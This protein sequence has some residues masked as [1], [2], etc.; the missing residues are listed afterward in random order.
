MAASISASAGGTIWAPVAARAA[1]AGAQVD[2]VAVVLRRVVA[3]GD[4]HAG[5]RVEGA[6]RVRQHRGGQH[7]RQHQRPAAGAGRDPG[8]LLGEGARAAAGVVADRPA[9]GR[10]LASASQATSPAAACRTTA[11]FMPFGPAR[12]RPA[13]P[14]GAEGQRSGEP[15]GELV[16]GIRQALDDGAQLRLAGRVGVVGQPPLGPVRSASTSMSP[17][18]S[19]DA[20]AEGPAVSRHASHASDRSRLAKPSGQTNWNERTISSKMILLSANRASG[21]V[22]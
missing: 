6:H 19:V 7:P 11:R 17:A 3:R 9:A 13:Q 15:V 18:S 22:R 10:R 20:C 8:G 4:H 5:A 2:L 16:G 21:T 14:G 12:M 1:E